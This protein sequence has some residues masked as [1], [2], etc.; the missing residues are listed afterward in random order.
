MQSTEPS[1]LRN[2]ERAES[3]I[4]TPSCVQEVLNA[5]VCAR[6]RTS[7]FD[8]AVDAYRARNPEASETAARAAV[9]SIICG[10]R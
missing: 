6:T 8:E 10:E 7:A 2:V 9:A 1:A 5:Y 3:T 4:E